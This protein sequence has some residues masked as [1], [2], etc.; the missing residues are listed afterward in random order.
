MNR[1]RGK[2]CKIANGYDSYEFLEGESALV[3]PLALRM[4]ERFRLTSHTLPPLPVI[5]DDHVSIRYEHMTLGWDN[6]S[7][8]FLFADSQEGNRV[9]HEIAAEIESLVNDLVNLT[10]DDRAGSQSE[11]PDASN[12]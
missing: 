6:W 8:L 7:G 11:Q 1:L 3:F 2:W 12:S 4:E 9:L 10:R 5:T